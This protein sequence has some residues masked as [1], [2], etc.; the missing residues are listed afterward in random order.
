MTAEQT[1]RETRALIVI[2]TFNNRSTARGVV[3]RAL[4][5]GLPVLVVNDG[6]TDGTRDALAGLLCER[7][8][9]A[10]NK[11]KGAAI[12]SGARWAAERGYTHI[13]TID[14]DGQH[15]PEDA[16]KFIAALRVDPWAVI[17]GARD[18]GGQLIP[19]ASRFGRGFSNFWLR[20]DAGVKLPD[21]Q[22]G[23]RAY[24][25]EV[26]LGL[27]CL[28]GRRYA[29]E[30]EI[31]VHAARAGVKLA[32]VPIGVHYPS[33]RVSHFR[34]LLDNILI[35]EVYARSFMRNFLPWP[36][37]IVQ[38]PYSAPDENVSRHPLHVLKRLITESSTPPRMAAS[39]ML[40]VFLGA[41]PLIA[42][43]S[44]AIMFCAGRL[45]LNRLMA[46][47]ASHICAP[48]F[49]PALAIEIGYYMRHGGFLT[50]LSMQT[51][52]HEAPQRL[53]EYLIG[54]FVIGPPLAVAAGAITYAA[55]IAWQRR[56]SRRA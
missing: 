28:N 13:V 17:V 35:S 42:C 27:S 54:S 26:I 30:V 37:R 8:D 49:V 2:P 43:H 22:S 56:K 21:S 25:V 6:S 48:P 50:E 36:Y 5:T 41:L 31:L 33:A 52:G 9:R 44:I 32:S 53:F 47:N 20:L 38:S 40:G 23:F 3:E 19:F 45:R 46:I 34:P 1:T 16:L 4:A 15:D 24:P 29:F 7:I 18:F 11:G 55:A 10:R 14:A 12:V 39:A 51:L